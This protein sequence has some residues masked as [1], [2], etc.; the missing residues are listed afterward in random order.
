MTDFF[1]FCL[2]I[3]KFL[4]YT[5]VFLMGLG[6]FLVATLPANF[7]WQS[8]LSPQINTRAMGLEVVSVDGTVWEGR[9]LISYKSVSSIIDW[10]ISVMDALSL[11]LPIEI[12]VDS[13]IGKAQLFASI[14]LSQSSLEIVKA[15][16]D[17]SKL[18]PIFQR[19]RVVLDGDL[20]VKNLRVNIN[21]QKISSASGLA[22]WSG[23]N[24]AYPVGRQLHERNLPSFRAELSSS[25]EGSV[26]IGV[27]DADAKFNVVDLNLDAEGEVMLKVTRR[28]L[29]I[30]NEAWPKNSREQDV[31][32]KVK[33]MIY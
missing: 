28:L 25:A 11:S 4:F 10:N 19:Q 26:Q 3:K 2:V 6:C 31:V 18:S 15:D 29:D 9:A 32:F 24:I 27:R 14:G 12:N 20:L 1:G 7:V 16:V 33:K 22:S 8:L 13:E 23:G 17:V 5:S 30:S 21:E